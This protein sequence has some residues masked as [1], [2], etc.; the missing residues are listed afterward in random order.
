MIF[1]VFAFSYVF[2]ILYSYGW[3][4]HK[5]LRTSDSTL[6][7]SGITTLLF[8]FAGT[9]TIAGFASLFI[10]I[11][12]EFQILLWLG[13]LAI[14][15]K[16]KLHQNFRLKSLLGFDAKKAAILV[17]AATSTFIIL[18][19]TSLPPANSD[20]GIY[21]AQAIHW[22][23][24]YPAV[25]GLANLHS[26]LGYNSS[27][28]L[29]NAI[30]SFP[31]L[32]IQ[33]FHFMTGFLFL[34][35]SLYFLA[36][37][38]NILEK[39]ARISDY[40]RTAFLP[41]LFLLLIDQSSSPS[42]DAPAAVLIW[43]ILAE[44]VRTL[45]DKTDTR[46]RLFTISL[47]SVYV[48]T[49]KLSAIPILLLLI[50]AIFEMYRT[51][52]K[53]YILLLFLL[54][55][56]IMLPHTIRN[57]VLTG[58]FLFPGPPIDIFRFDWR[59]PAEELQTQ[60]DSIRWF[61]TL[62]RMNRQEFLE[63]S[64]IEWLPV[65]FDNLI[66]R[67]KAILLATILLPCLHVLLL[68]FKPWRAHLTENKRFFIPFII[69]YLG[70]VFWFS[71]APNFRFGSGFIAG[72]LMLNLAFLAFFLVIQSNLLNTIIRY[73]ALPIVFG[74]ILLFSQPINIG[75][76]LRGHIILPADYPSWSSEPCT[77]KNFTILCQV[78]YNACWYKPF[79]CAIKGDPNVEMRGDDFR[80]GF[81]YNPAP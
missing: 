7:A 19:A 62:P 42:T 55:A 12:W 16:F 60:V 74:L 71:S 2:V 52:A 48:V 45:E 50:F 38:Q 67:Y 66:P 33:S 69:I 47:I 41:A 13:A 44:S 29:T 59:V 34:A 78:R 43:I 4:L 37:L 3:M 76:G 64:I 30:F 28:L 79:P 32:G 36:G 25:P 23:E 27:W 15:L 31:Y 40:L 39:N 26:R 61:A 11:N 70:L 14:I 5:H 8:G 56:A 49:I 57:L 1:L 63:L 24:S 77:F 17:I 20:T 35:A 6:P 58:Y 73:L 18:Y 68:K 81:R 80:E 51:G 10:R 72:G 54:S 22:I 75:N 21:H 46:K 9:T 65:W 53:K